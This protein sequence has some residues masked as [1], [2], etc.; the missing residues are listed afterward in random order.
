LDVRGIPYRN[1]RNGRVCAVME[2]LCIKR[3]Y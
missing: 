3:Q 1:R 2:W